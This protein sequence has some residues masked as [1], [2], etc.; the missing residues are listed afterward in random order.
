MWPCVRWALAAAAILA[1]GEPTL[2]TVPPAILTISTMPELSG[3]VY[4]RALDR[5]LVI[6]DDTGKKELGTAHAP[7]LYTLRRDGALDDAPLPIMGIDGLNDGEAIC[8]GPAGSFFLTTSHSKNRKGKHKAARNQLLRLELSGRALVATAAL[9][10]ADVIG[11]SGVLTGTDTD[12]IDVEGLAYREGALYV[13]LKAPQT[14]EGAALIVRVA[15][16][17]GSLR[18]GELAPTQVSRYAALPLLVTTA[19]GPT[20]QGISDLSFLPDG[21]LA[22]LANSPKGLPHD[23]G[24]ALW[25]L[26]P[27]QPVQLIRR[28]AGLKPEG[29][30]LTP[31][32]K[33]LV[34][35]F[36][37]DR[38]T[39]MWL[40]QPLPTAPATPHGAA[41]PKTPRTGGA[42]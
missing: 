22:I 16:I 18:R 21:S 3:L 12:R 37:R 23:G 29:V 26:R 7:W 32:Q 2:V 42:H 27:G 11:A 15:D 17:D 33:A 41:R 38:E 13:G 19:A 14:A 5:Y 40:H 25:W 24:G 31:D 9:D 20:Q 10:L 8:V 35:V 4:S 39:P 1:P 34:I 36:D 30:T 6:S 28:F